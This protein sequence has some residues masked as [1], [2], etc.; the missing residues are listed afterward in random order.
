MNIGLNKPNDDGRVLFNQVNFN[1]INQA[2]NVY[3]FLVS[4][5]NN[6][7]VNDNLNYVS[8][9]QKSSIVN[10]F[11]DQQQANVNIV[12]VDPVYTSFSL[13]VRTGEPSETITK[14]ISEESFLVIKRDVL[15]N[16]S[17]QALKERI[18]NIFVNYFE[19]LNLGDLVSLKELSNQIFSVGG[20]DDI[21]TRR[22]TNKVTVNEVEGINLIVYNPIYPQNDIE[23]ISSDLLLPFFKYPYLKGKS[24]LS[25]IIIENS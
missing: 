23:L 6:V 25:N 16:T 21:R 15:S 8:T 5:F 2:N 13:G 12:P 14:D 20:V 9:S 3:L 1:S 17:T 19:A 7:D 22:I 10:S 18:N 24:I 4:K 11:Q